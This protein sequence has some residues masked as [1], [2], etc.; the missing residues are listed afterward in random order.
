[1]N[2]RHTIRA[3]ATA[4]I[5]ASVLVHASAG[6]AATAYVARACEDAVSVLDTVAGTEIDNIFPSDGPSDLVVNHAKSRVYAYESGAITAIDTA[7]NSFI[8]AVAISGGFGR[9]AMHPADSYVYATDWFNGSVY[10]V[11]AAG[12]TLEKTLDLNN[13]EDIVVHPDG[14]YVYVARSIPGEPFPTG[15]VTRI[16]TAGHTAVGSIFL[17]LNGWGLAISPSGDRLYAF[18][19]DLFTVYVAVIDTATFTKIDDFEVL[20]IFYDMEV[21][22]DGNRLYAV[23]TLGVSVY[24]LPSGALIT[25]VSMPDG[26]EIE[27]A[28]D[29]ASLLVSRYDSDQVSVID[30]TTNAIVDSIPVDC[31][32]GI[33][34]GPED[35]D[36]DALLDP[37]DNCTT[38][39]NPDQ[40]DT[41]QDSI[42]NLCDADFDQSCMVDFTDVGEI[43]SVFFQTGDLE[44]DMNG[45]GSVNFSDLGLVKASMFEEP[46]PSGLPN[47]CN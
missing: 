25:T 4:G 11:S 43:K 24:D 18:I 47:L 5:A 12:L 9:L 36:G 10:V 33:G 3:V 44:E 15:A 28:P 34:F 6:I 42:G 41:D 8:D 21:S 35:F 17:G 45:D 30:T 13:P 16:E 23:G 46:G 22:P 19:A 32:D 7:S 40:H 39:Y 31:P 20:D 38:R 26:I 1:M 14:S 29:G 2:G 27:F 37:F